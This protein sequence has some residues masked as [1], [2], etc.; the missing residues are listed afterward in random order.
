LDD[1]LPRSTSNPEERLMEYISIICWIL[2]AL[3]NSVM[4]TLAHH[5]STSI[6]KNMN[7]KFWNLKISWKNKYKEGDKSMGSA[8]YLST[9]ILVA[10][11][12]G[13]HL[14]KSSMIVLLAISVI[15]FPY[16]YQICIFNNIILNNISW[17]IILG[18]TWNI[19]FSF[20][21][22]NALKNN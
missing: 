3:C 1:G 15:M 5:Y 20:M 19:P 14:F 11:T 4:D 21:Y 2:A 10:F 6:F 18:V 7:P 17:I 9:G 16:T 22:N 12:D 8:F 13:W